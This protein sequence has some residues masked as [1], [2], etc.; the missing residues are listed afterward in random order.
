MTQAV[1]THAPF[2][3][4]DTPDKAALLKREAEHFNK[5]YADE[6]A[7]GITP[8]TDF[9]KLRYTA[10]PA[11]TIF[12]REYFYHLLAPLRG[13][14]VMEIAA[15]NGIDASLCA[16]NGA[17]VHAY[18]LSEKS[19]DMVRRRAKVN[20][21]AHRV[22]T[23]V[24]G[25]FDTAFLGQTFDAILGYAALHHLTD[26]NTLNQR[27]FDRLNP[28]GVAVF[29][30]PVVNSKALDRL[31]KMI[32]YSIHDMTEDE[33]PM[34]DKS[35]ADFAWPFERMARREFQLT[36][37]LWPVFPSNWPLAVAL[38]KL[39]AGLLKLPMMRRFA[40]V[41]VFGLYKAA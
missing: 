40:T 11:N 16:H 34:N 23:E 31:R 25:D 27:I 2:A 14:D 15:G 7:R 3:P 38:H 36:S 17:T 5:H 29:A 22:H 37:R 21:V 33:T 19:I 20:G 13:K 24:T 39:D 18:D 26:L 8:L 41:V 4:P 32:P 12:P 6:A 28:G 35:I 9:D 10:P 1:Q 30:E